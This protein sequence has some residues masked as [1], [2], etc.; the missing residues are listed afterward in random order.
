MSDEFTFA[1]PEL[2]V[3]P[4]F[5]GF[6]YPSFMT[7]APWKTQRVYALMG[8]NAVAVLTAAGIKPDSVRASNQE[9]TAETWQTVYFKEARQLEAN[10]AAACF[11]SKIKTPTASLQRMFFAQC[12]DTLPVSQFDLTWEQ[13]EVGFGAGKHWQPW[14]LVTVPSMVHAYA[15]A[16]G[17]DVPELAFREISDAKNI[18]VDFNVVPAI[19]DGYL[20]QRRELWNALGEPE[21]KNSLYQGAKDN[22]G[23]PVTAGVTTSE[24]L[25]EALKFA[26]GEWTGAYY[27]ALGQCGHPEGNAANV[28]LG[29]LTKP[30]KERIVV[31]NGLWANKAAAEAFVASRGRKDEEPVAKSV[32]ISKYDGLPIPDEFS[33][34]NEAMSAKDFF[35]AVYGDTIQKDEAATKATG[36]AKIAAKKALEAKLAEYGQTLETWGKIKELVAG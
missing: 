9:V 6:P 14:N 12:A 26:L 4:V 22:K 34:G 3:T 28:A 29:Y 32:A 20:N 2:A 15:V 5:T 23:K 36:A 33:T 31:C 27:T 10:A 19:W 21:A 30:N 11:P 16:R 25:S 17:W 7:I 1:V 24:K 13:H 35:E 8:Q 18:Q